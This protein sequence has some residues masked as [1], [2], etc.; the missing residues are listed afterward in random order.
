MKYLLVVGFACEVY[1]KEPRARLFFNEKLIDEF[2]IAHQ[3]EK[4]FINRLENLKHPL[5]PR[6]GKI[7]DEYILNTLP[8]LRF[9]SIDV[10]D[11]LKK[12]S[13]SIDIDND[14]SNYTNGFETHSTKLQ[15]T[16]LSLLPVDRKIYE[17][18][19]IK[20]RN[21]K[22]TTEKYA[23]YQKKKYNH[24]F[25]LRRDLTWLGRNGQK[26]DKV[27]GY[28]IGGSG[29]FNCEVIKKYGILL[30]KIQYP[31]YAYIYST[32]PD[33]NQILYDKYEKHANQRNTD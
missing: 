29:Y 10:D 2:Y 8:P 4:K 1:K 31:K 33:L 11:R 16:V 6:F 25:S 30:G 7:I 21:K 15:F 27:V 13:I 22:Y 28:T 17:W 32:Q 26:F 18:F 20:A 23:W 3:I 12:V 5:E 24:F 19:F 9:Y 14:D